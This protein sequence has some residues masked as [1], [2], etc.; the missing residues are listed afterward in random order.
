MSYV[1]SVVDKVTA[2]TLPRKV[3]L[4]LLDNPEEWALE[5]RRMLCEKFKHKETGW[6]FYTGSNMAIIRNKNFEFDIG[7]L[8]YLWFNITKKEFKFTKQWLKL[9][10]ELND[11]NS[12]P[13]D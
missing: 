13:V 11:T 7:F 5:D 9:Q 6:Y 3:I 8:R 1:D 12:N 2:G 4:K 10:G